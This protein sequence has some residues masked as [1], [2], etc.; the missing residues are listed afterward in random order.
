MKISTL[1]DA[2]MLW[3]HRGLPPHTFSAV[4]TELGICLCLV[5][6][7]VNHTTR[8][9]QVLESELRRGSYARPKVAILFF[10]SGWS[11]KPSHSCYRLNLRWCLCFEHVV[12]S[13]CNAC[14]FGVRSP[15]QPSHAP[16]KCIL[17]SWTESDQI[18]LMYTLCSHDA[19]QLASTPQ[20]L[21]NSAWN[22]RMLK[23]QKME[24]SSITLAYINHASWQ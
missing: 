2:Q 24:S 10:V 17:S 12:Q 4:G 9:S 1:S 11:H 6:K 5:C 21:C 8:Q 19:P 20:N 7:I 18:R 23:F 3:G 13:P 22:T 16:L 15:L 14:L